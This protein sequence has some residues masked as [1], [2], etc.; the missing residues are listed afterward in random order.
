LISCTCPLPSKLIEPEVFNFDFKAKSILSSS[1]S[2]IP[3]SSS[4]EEEPVSSS[5]I[6]QESPVIPPVPETIK[7]DES[8]RIGG[9]LMV[10]IIT[11]GINTLLSIFWLAK[12]SIIA[13]SA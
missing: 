5:S 7:I 11:M 2:E 6:V 9:W 10:V 1:S 13:T 8:W 4:S 3:V 12:S